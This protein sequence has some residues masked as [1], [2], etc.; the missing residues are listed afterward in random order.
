MAAILSV[1]DKDLRM[2]YM[3]AERQNA[4]ASVLEIFLIV[5]TALSLPVPYTCAFSLFTRIGVRLACVLQPA[6]V[7]LK[8]A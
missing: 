5:C 1:A 6:H 8:A 7:R 3:G 2:F 4:H